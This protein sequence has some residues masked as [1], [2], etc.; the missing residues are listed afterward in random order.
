LFIKII[1]GNFLSSNSFQA[2]SVPTST[3]AVASKTSTAE[4]D[5]LN[6][7]TTSP[8]KSKYPG[9]SRKLILTS[10]CSTGIRDVFI[11]KI[12]RTS[13]LSKSETVVPFSTSPFLLI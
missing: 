7:D 12:L 2:F 5:T 10:L 3:P 8:I 13:S 6:A 1:L 9:V 11:E 4:A